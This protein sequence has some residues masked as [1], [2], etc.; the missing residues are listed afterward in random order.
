M[1]I[2]DRLASF[3]AYKCGDDK[4]AFAELMG[5]KRQYMNKLLK[6]EGGIGLNPI[7]AL[8]SK[9]PELNARWLILGEG[10]MVEGR[11]FTL[12]RL[13]A[14]LELER[15]MP[16]MDADELRA[17]CDEGRVDWDGSTL[18][19]WDALLADRQARLDQR[20]T[21]AYKRQKDL[22]DAKSRE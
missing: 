14:M 11:G 16:V 7:A 4:A 6:G 1:E 13:R 21:V 10:S 2:N 12:S 22:L 15:F 18:A 3:I 17:F 20:F 19:K 9:F 5:W 8:L